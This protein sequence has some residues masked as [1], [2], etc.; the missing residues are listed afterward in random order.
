MGSVNHPP[1]RAPRVVSCA[2][3]PGPGN[4]QWVWHGVVAA[5]RKPLVPPWDAPL[6]YRKPKGQNNGKYWWM[7]QMGNRL[8]EGLG[9]HVLDAFEVA[10]PLSS[11]LSARLGRG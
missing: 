8:F 11:E 9:V 4:T 10:I 7:N 1:L 2:S 6:Y 5:P 3:S